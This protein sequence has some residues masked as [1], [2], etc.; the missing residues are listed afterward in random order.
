LQAEKRTHGKNV[1]IIDG[2]KIN[3]RTLE[4]DENPDSMLKEIAS[5]LQKSLCCGGTVKDG[6]I[7]LQTK[8]A[9]GVK[10]LLEND[11]GLEGIQV[12]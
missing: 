9:T 5:T 12:L 4:I 6:K 3:S 2:I 7:T 8:D 11:F 1:L 10:T